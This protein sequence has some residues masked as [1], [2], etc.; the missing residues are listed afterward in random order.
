MT[1]RSGFELTSTMLTISGLVLKRYIHH[2]ATLALDYHHLQTD[3]DERFT[4]DV[5]FVFASTCFS[6]V[7]VLISLIRCRVIVACSQNLIDD[8]EVRG[9]SKPLFGK[10]LPSAP[11]GSDA[12]S[13][14][15]HQMIL[16]LSPSSLI[17]VKFSLAHQTCTIFFRKSCWTSRRS[18]TLHRGHHRIYKDILGKRVVIDTWLTST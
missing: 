14:S 13:I 9:F 4:I 6:I 18:E 15:A 1:L 12:G 2:V 8:L 17:F 10:W 7:W 16:P 11:G 5:S 3:I